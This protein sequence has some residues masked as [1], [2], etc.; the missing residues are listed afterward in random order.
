MKRLCL[1]LALT[2][3]AAMM[4]A[5][6][7]ARAGDLRD[8]TMA[9]GAATHGEVPW[10]EAAS[11]AMFDTPVIVY[12]HGQFAG[13]GRFELQ[14]L[15]DSQ[16]HTVCVMPSRD[17]PRNVREDALARSAGSWI[18]R[19]FVREGHPAAVVVSQL[20]NEE[21]AVAGPLPIP[22]A[23][24]E[25]TQISLSRTGCFGTCPAYKVTISGTGAVHLRAGGNSMI[26]G[27]FDW[28]IASGDVS[29]LLKAFGAAQFWALNNRYV[30]NVT[31]NPTFVVSLK[32]GAALK[33]VTDYVGG[34]V[35]M[36]GSVSR[37]EHL[38][39][40]TSG[41]HSLVYG[42][43]N[44]LSRLQALHFDFHDPRVAAVMNRRVGEASADEI[45]AFLDH[46]VS[47]DGLPASAALNRRFDLFQMALSR[48]VSLDAQTSC[49]LESGVAAGSDAEFFMAFESRRGG[50]CHPETI[51]LDMAD[52]YY[53]QDA[54][55][56]T[57]KICNAAQTY[58][59]TPDHVR[60]LKYLIDHKANMYA[61]GRYG[62]QPVDNVYDEASLKAYTDAGYDLNRPNSR[63][64]TPLMRSN[65]ADLAFILLKGGADPFLKDKDGSDFYTR[66][67]AGGWHE[68]VAWIDARYPE[69]RH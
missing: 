45:A 26:A 34:Y 40:T 44:T 10:S 25:E 23:A 9:D 5:P 33:S 27:D 53:D 41:A 58:C 19:P 7:L 66:A 15:V 65:V 62:E 47:P 35:G 2:L 1:T 18:Y 60:I 36:P 14:A 29:E 55:P 24:P 67:K 6:A 42:D 39:D 28:S 32:R 59:F 49:D 8:C 37:L 20:V 11:H 4:T 51:L 31:D 43:E 50:L 12:P 13:Q 30:S 17:V 48:G 22:V 56:E 21:E 69:H 64:E 46:G 16:G 57:G 54:D 3:G 52:H 63:G 38:I 68:L 61:E